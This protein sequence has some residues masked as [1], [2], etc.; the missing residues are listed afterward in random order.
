MRLAFV[1]PAHIVLPPPPSFLPP[2]DTIQAI[3]V[4]FQPPGGQVMAMYSV[5]NDRLQKEGGTAELYLQRGSCSRNAPV[6]WITATFDSSIENKQL[7]HS[8]IVQLSFFTSV[9]VAMQEGG[10]AFPHVW[11]DGHLLLHRRL[12][13]SLVSQAVNRMRFVAVHQGWANFL[14]GE[15]QWVL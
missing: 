12:L 10:A 6:F 3:Q 2:S 14:I 7:H 11:Q 13:F 5:G 8:W 4:M 9:S 1:Q 15:P